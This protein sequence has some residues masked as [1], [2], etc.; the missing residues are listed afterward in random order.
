MQLSIF[1]AVINVDES[2]R[3]SEINSEADLSQEI[4]DIFRH[5]SLHRQ[6]TQMPLDCLRCEIRNLIK[7]DSFTFNLF[8]V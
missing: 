5:R 6:F 1:V 7:S 4:K 3:V 2:F 8:K